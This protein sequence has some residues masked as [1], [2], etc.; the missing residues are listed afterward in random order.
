MTLTIESYTLGPLENRTVLCCNSANQNAIIIDPAYGAEEIL[1]DIKQNG[2]Q[3]TAIYLTHAHFDHIAG[4]AELY[5]QTPGGIPIHLHSGDLVW[6]N[7]GGGAREFGFHIDNDVPV[8]ADLDPLPVI[9]LGGSIMQV[10]FTPGHTPGHVIFYLPEINTAAVGDVIFRMGV[11]RTALPGG[12]GRT[13][14]H[15]IQTQ[16]LTLPDETILLPGHGLETTVGFE[17]LNNPFF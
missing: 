2:L 1:A 16:V 17:R 7:Q 13:L 3:L 12:D 10:R 6:W 11:G 4:A 5:R 9:D 8:V 14:I 15:S